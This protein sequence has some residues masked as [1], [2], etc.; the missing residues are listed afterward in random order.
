MRKHG[1]NVKPPVVVSSGDSTLDELLGGGFNKYLVYLLCG[2]KKATTD[3]LLTTA[4]NVQKAT[5][6]DGFGDDIKVAFLDGVNRFDPYRVS[7][8][9]VSQNLSP[10]QILSNILIARAF[11][12]DQ[13]V[14]L[15]E[16]RLAQLDHVKVVLIS[17]IT[18]LF[19]G[20]ENQS[21]EYVLKAIS[22][23][24]K[25]LERTNPLIVISAP[26][27]EFSSFNP[28]RGKE[29]SNSENVV[30]MIK[31][32][33]RYIEYTLV[34]HPFIPEKSLLK[35]KPRESRRRASP[36]NAQIDLWF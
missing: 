16:N 36:R 30:V 10:R 4:V 3:V 11:T 35:W 9:A 24:K 20:F 31:N 12:W 8:Y 14:E 21:L 19:Q 17:G 18:S 2:N 32:E 5:Y 15:L 7:K 22:E 28:K 26:L 29:L 27:N 1:I 34:Q 25:I 6:N 13:T 33:D 23:I